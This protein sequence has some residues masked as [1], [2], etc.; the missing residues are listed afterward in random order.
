MEQLAGLISATWP[1]VLIFWRASS[2]MARLAAALPWLT[3][4]SMGLG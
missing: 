2:V 4:S 1:L 3:A